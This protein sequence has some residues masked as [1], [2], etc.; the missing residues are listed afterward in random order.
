ME[1]LRPGLWR[2]TAPHPDWTPEEGGAD[3][4]ER[5]VACYAYA[6]A[7]RLMLFDPLSPPEEIER[8]AAERD[9]VDVALTGEWHAR[10]ANELRE[11]LGATVYAPPPAGEE[12]TIEATRIG[13]N[14]AL[15]A[16]VD[17]RA[18][19]YPAEVVYWIAEHGALVFGDAIL[20]GRPGGVRIQ[21]S[22]LPP[23]VTL[24]QFKIALRPLLQLPV[25]LVL[26]T[27]GEAAENGR[28]AL[29]Q[30]LAD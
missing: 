11:R 16:A 8:L 20:G 25:E 3:G 19:S 1:E 27:H 12:P 26:P 10:S 28:E 7:D 5:D 18:T 21:E 4:W 9:A 22:W 29:R 17:V 2:W 13:P 6:T 15:S 23:D 30:A 14:D 24:E